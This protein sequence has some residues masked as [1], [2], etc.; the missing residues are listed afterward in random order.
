[1][2]ESIHEQLFALLSD[3]V[4]EVRSAAISALNTLLGSLEKTDPVVFFDHSVIMSVL[5]ATLN[6]ASPLVR[7]ETVVILSQFVA[8]YPSKMTAVATE[9][10]EEE[11]QKAGQSRTGR[12]S[13]SRPQSM[14]PNTDIEIHTVTSERSLWN[15]ASSPIKSPRASKPVLLSTLY[16]IVW[17]TLLN[18]SVDSFP[19]VS[20]LASQVVDKVMSR[21][22]SLSGL[23]NS[24]ALSINSLNIT[25]KLANLELQSPRLNTMPS[26]VTSNS[27]HNLPS[28]APGPATARQ[29]SS[30]GSKDS[31]AGSTTIGRMS[32][33][34]RRSASIA[35]SSLFGPTAP[36]PATQTE[37]LSDTR[38]ASES[39]ATLARAGSLKRR[40]SAPAHSSPKSYSDRNY[41][42]DKDRLALDSFL[43]EWSLEYFTEPQMKVPDSEDPGTHRYNQRLWRVLRNERVAQE[44]AKVDDISAP[45]GF[46]EMAPG[47][48]QDELHPP[49]K[50]LFHTYDP[51]LLSVDPFSRIWLA[52]AFVAVDKFLILEY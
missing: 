30:S 36:I 18:M 5:E 4:P 41:A 50:A 42:A 3:P 34:L 51:H 38:S 33:T 24:T 16:G 1:V 26:R 28:L 13:M 2:N 35:F 47:G 37:S 39:R 14:P 45:T 10:V 43:F 40:P 17:K 20:K 52:F 27:M 7:S 44:T 11:R 19:V 8:Q 9:L 21:V 25:P 46:L 22:L 32:L 23:V 12:Q 48:L 49:V 15:D 29:T 6:D 31:H